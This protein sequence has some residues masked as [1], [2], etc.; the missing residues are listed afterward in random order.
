[1]IEEEHPFGT[2]GLLGPVRM[3]TYLDERGRLTVYGG[4]EQS[5][6]YDHA[7]DPAET[8][9]LHDAPEGDKLRQ[10]LTDALARELIEL[11]DRGRAPTSS[12]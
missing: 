2:P 9:N 8:H 11:A 5:E 7:L 6:L 3:R 12:A 1:M 10:Q 4:Q